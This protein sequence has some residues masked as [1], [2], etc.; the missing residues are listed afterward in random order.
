VSISLSKSILPLGSALA[1]LALV[2]C[3]GNAVTGA[4]SGGSGTGAS[5]AVA[6]TGDAGNTSG[7][8]GSGVSTGGDGGTTAATGSSS[9]SGTPI[10]HRPTPIACSA[11][12]VS[13]FGQEDAGAVSCMTDLDCQGDASYT[14][15]R[16]CLHNLCR[17][18]QCLTDSDCSSDSVCACADQFIG[19]ALHTNLCLTAGC[20]VDADCASGLCSPAGGENLCQPFSGYRCRS[21]ADGCQSD[22]DCPPGYGTG[23]T[24]PGL[25]SYDSTSGHWQCEPVCTAAG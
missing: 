2:G 10:A 9:D 15:Y 7:A 3:G 24:Q 4:G 11:T 21:A 19:N 14:L 1:A 22:S 20:H 18:D 8:N 23:R 13:E 6:S 5:G 12:N 25:C 17:A 16:F